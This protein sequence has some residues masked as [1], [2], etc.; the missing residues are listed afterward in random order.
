[1]P[2][3][4]RGGDA[5]GDSGGDYGAGTA[6]AVISAGGDYG[7]WGGDSAAATSAAATS[8]GSQ[9]ARRRESPRHAE[10]L[11]V[12]YLLF[13]CLLFGFQN[14]LSNRAD[15]PPSWRSSRS[16]MARTA[17]SSMRPSSRSAKAPC[18]VPTTLRGKAMR[19]PPRATCATPGRAFVGVLRM[20]GD[21]LADVGQC[22]ASSPGAGLSVNPS[23]TSSAAACT[24]RSALRV[25]ASSEARS[26]SNDGPSH[27]IS[28]GGRTLKEQ[29]PDADGEGDGLDGC[30]LGD[31]SPST[32]IS[33]M[34]EAAAKV[35]TPRM[36]VQDTTTFSCHVS[37]R[38]STRADHPPPFCVCE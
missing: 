37:E 10:V 33:G 28:G 32:V 8:A 30:P 14:R 24:I 35:T 2:D 23:S 22:R 36:P 9:G 11:G 17:S 20:P 3:W 26:A 7:G 34:P 16:S 6:A 29:R 13:P 5:G 19:T 31:G 4:T 27:R 15:T 12:T 18:A 38:R 21:G 25:S 1:M